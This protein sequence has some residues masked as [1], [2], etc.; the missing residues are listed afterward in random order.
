MSEKFPSRRLWK[1]GLPNR[2]T[3]PKGGDPPSGGSPPQRGGKART[4]PRGGKPLVVGVVVPRPPA[5]VCACVFF[6]HAC[7]LPVFRVADRVSCCA[8]AAGQVCRPDFLRARPAGPAGRRGVVD[9]AR[10]QPADVG[11]CDRVVRC[12]GMPGRARARR[13]SCDAS[14]ALLC[15]VVRSRARPAPAGPYGLTRR[16]WLYHGRRN[17]TGMPAPVRGRGRMVSPIDVVHERRPAQLGGR[18]DACTWSTSS[19][20]NPR[21]IPA[22]R[23]AARPSTA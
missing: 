16:L 5:A 21:S 6:M 14:R 3:P 9:R 19:L 2:Q 22:A 20:E 17:Y 10:A 8:R 11:R 1:F 18:R 23:L 7:S 12:D 13:G 4:P 15:G